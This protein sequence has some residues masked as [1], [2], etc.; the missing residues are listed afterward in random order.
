[1]SKQCLN[2]YDFISQAYNLLSSCPNESTDLINALK[3]KTQKIQTTTKTMHP[4][5]KGTYNK[6]IT[7]HKLTSFQVESTEV[8]KA[9]SRKLFE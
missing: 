9:H 4:H 3:I 5:G 2:T 6:V 1:M 7:Q 8:I